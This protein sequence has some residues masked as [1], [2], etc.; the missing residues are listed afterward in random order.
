MFMEQAAASTL[1]RVERSKGEV[2]S[3]ALQEVCARS[4]AP[5]SF[6]RAVERRPGE[7]INVIAEVKR[8]SPSR[9]AIRPDLDLERLVGSY[10]R[11]GACAVSVLTEPEFFAGSMQDLARARCATALPL[12]RK[13]FI[14][15]PFQLLEARA[16]G[17]SAALLIAALLPED[18]LPRLLRAAQSLGLD[19][20]VEVH[21]EAELAAALD[22]GAGII[23]IN[24]RDLRT[25]EVD[26]ETTR[27]L[28][29]LV[30]AEKVLVSESGYTRREQVAPLAELGVDAVLVGEA[31]A[32]HEDPERA[33]R[34]LR[35]DGH[36]PA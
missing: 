26:L 21:D 15:D 30:P 16:G 35:G 7:T 20:L 22:A 36:A 34:E 11:G 6:R 2:S 27:R 25:L 13:D 10:E 1:E 32:R 31:L 33:L 18:E 23:G 3:A 17:A 24:N 29:P 9:G 4:Q 28:A 5:P 12:L 14:L 19:A 8:S